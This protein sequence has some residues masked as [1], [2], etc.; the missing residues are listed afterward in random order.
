MYISLAARFACEFIRQGSNDSDAIA[1]DAVD[2]AMAIVN[3]VAELDVTETADE[4][5]EAA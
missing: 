1:D 4:D 5:S 3:K 2:I